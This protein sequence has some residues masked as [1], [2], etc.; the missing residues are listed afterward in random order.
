[1][2]V[3]RLVISGFRGWDNLDLRPVGHVLLAGVPRA[4]RSD[5][6]AA[7]VRVLDPDTARSP[8]VA[9]L[10]Q[11]VEAPV[12]GESQVTTRAEVAE[13]EVTLSDLDPDAQQLF[14]GCLEPL[15]LSGAASDDLDANPFTPLC[16]RLAY[17]LTY[18]SDADVLD[19]VTYYPALSNPAISQY[20]RV[21]A[22]TRRALPV[23]NLSVSQP[24]QLRPGGRLRQIIDG[25]DP[26][27]AKQ[28]FQRL[29]DAVNAAIGAL[30]TDPAITEAVDAVLQS[31]G[32]GARLG[33]V[34][35]TSADVGFLAEDG[36]IAALLRTLQAAMRLDAAGLLALT[37]QGSTATA[38]LSVAEAMLLANVPGA[39][40]LA[41]D[42]GDRLDTAAAEH[43]ASVLRARSGQVWLSTRR[44]EVAR[45][46]EPNELVRLVRHGGTRAHHQ[47]S[48]I[49]DRKALTAVRQL[50]TQLLAALTAPTVAIT[51]GPHDVAVYAKVD[52][53]Y[54]PGALPLSAH[55]V[56]LVA[57]GT[58]QD[59]GIDQIPR[60]A[61]LARSLGFRVVALID[62]DKDSPQSQLQLQKIQETSDVVI[63]L[64]AGAIER[65]MLAGIGI[66][67]VAGASSAL[68]AYG[69]PD[70]VA[71]LAGEAA[72]TKLCQVTHKQG[73]HE[74]LLE[75][76]YSETGVHPP[77]IKVVL[78]VLGAVASPTY[79]GATLID[80]AEIP[81]PAPESS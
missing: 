20:V 54:P 45:A 65:A 21:P 60:V 40:V 57:A 15:D 75:A 79:S 53:R 52:R 12:P 2:R 39:I 23:I 41:D 31:G 28:A 69:I 55:G 24:M 66:D 38:I 80:L 61:S 74:Q 78:D 1:M 22:T 58:G 9:D 63:R 6:I 18:D 77:M 44:P 46:F 48:T 19:T 59:G 25:R 17:R 43:L 42:F 11:H 13:I 10:R 34:P 14:D 81:R 29:Y 76:L 47:L 7:L 27:A 5:V 62:R 67:K 72:F 64:P 49:T 26:L 37:N 8:S 68:T 3:T 51:E 33:D 56:R 73:L 30:S 4:G 71:G 50:H 36:S 16:V 35:I 70:P 32:A